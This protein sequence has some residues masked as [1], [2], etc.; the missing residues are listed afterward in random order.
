MGADFEK[1]DANKLNESIFKLIG[2]DWMLIT[3]GSPEHYNM[4]TASWGTAG[5]LWNKPIAIIFVRPQR[6]TYNFLEKN[7]HFTLN[8]FDESYRDMLN[9]MGTRS[10]REINK[11]ETQNLKA[12]ESENGSVY[13]EQARIVLEC[14]KIYHDDIKPEL[15]ADP[16]LHKMYPSEDYHRMYIG[17]LKNCMIKRQNP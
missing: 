8:F 3:C 7:D 11:M 9:V 1:T 2:K 5:V 6:Y 12:V 13:F 4:M 17:E 10:G 14:H 15:F 16:S